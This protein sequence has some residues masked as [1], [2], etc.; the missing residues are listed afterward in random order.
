MA[1]QNDFTVYPTSKV[2]RHTSGTTVY[3]A[4]AFYSW[5]MNTFDEPGYLTYETPIRF[6]T[7]TSFTMINGWFLDD[8]DGN[9]ADTEDGHILKYITGGGIDT[10][11]YATVSDPIYMADLATSTVDFVYTD[12]D[13][14]VTSGAAVGP[15]LAYK[16]DY[17]TS[18]RIR[19]WVRDTESHGALATS[20]V[21]EV[22]TAGGSGTGTTD[23]TTASVSG[24]EIYHNLFTIASF[25]T[26]VYPQVYVYQRHPVTTQSYN[27]R[28]RIAE[29]SGFTNWDRGSDGIDVLIPVKLGGTAVDGGNL[30]AFVRETG[31]TYTFVKSTLTSSGRTPIATETS[32]D[33]VNITEGEHYLLYDGS[34]TGSFSADDVITDSDVSTG[35]PPS[36][37]A[38]VVEVDEFTATATGLLTIRSLHGTISDNDDI[39]VTA[40]SAGAPVSV[41]E[42]TVNGTVGDTLVTHTGAGTEP[43]IG[44]IDLPF[45]G[46]TSGAHR[47]LR[48]YDNAENKLVMQVYHTFGTLDSQVYTG[49]GRDALYIDFSL[50]E[51][52]DA[53]ASGTGLMS[54]TTSAVSTT[55]ISGFSDVTVAHMNGT[56]TVSG[57]ANGPLIL[58]DRFTYNTGAQSGILIY[59]DS[60]TAPTSLMLGNIDPDNEPDASDQFAFQLAGSGA[61]TVDCDSVLTDNN[62]QNFE[63]TLQSTGAL[64]TIFIEGGSI[65]NAGRSLADIY[66]YLQYYVRDGQ[67]ISERTIYTSDGTAITKLAAEEYIKAVDVTAYSAT[68]PA[69]F[70]TLAG[71]T[72]FGAQGVWLQGMTST[73]NN[74]IK[75]ID[76]G[77]SPTWVGTLREPDP[78]INLTISNTRVGDRIAV[79]LES[80][81]TTL[82]D[83]AQYTSHATL[84][85][86]S[87]S[88]FD[89]NASDGAFPIDTPTFG[90]FIAVATDE[91]EEHRYR[92][93]SYNATGGGGSDGQLVLPTERTGTAT[94]GSTGQTLVASAATFVSW[95]DQNGL[96][97]QIGD[98]IRR[99]NNEG[100]WA[101]ITS[102]DSETQV[103]T[104]LFNAGITQGWDDTATADTF[105][106]LSLV[107]LYDD[108]DTFFIPYMDFRES[109]GTDGSPGSETVTVLYYANREV[110]IEVRNVEASTQ[111]IPFKT[112]GTI[113]STGLTQSVI[114]NEDT[115]YT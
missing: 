64:Y 55:L 73:D 16:N 85:A 46:G 82:P 114:R 76:A 8:G 89:R 60:L 91:S 99:T 36:W 17:P 113:S 47:V 94:A 10:S 109:A 111:I 32:A 74:N 43:V 1:I 107:Q 70:G 66:A 39:Y 30:T 53:P 110:V 45:E 2:I 12:K 63:F 67:N 102:I 80:G 59:A 88:T 56:V 50:T 13:L 71:T 95:V 31:D 93:T 104:T 57:I 23:G 48:G 7:P 52:V 38:E 35:V 41:L 40:Y 106:M 18:A 6:N 22:T 103:T 26:D 37:Y 101:Y 24:D 75:F 27:T 21:T 62:S 33:E 20:T 25:P 86:Q 42:G 87:D 4:V 58:G 77:T 54:V 69:P 29:W 98:I 14:Q 51:V 78:S 79:Y 100:G 97:T 28:V 3:S 83:K 9:P 90:T 19:I 49:S 5:L 72:F 108:S 81:S 44:D 84:N 92:Y 11:G 115:V 68:K 96:T 105:E 34:D 65:Y 15:L 112:T 61:C